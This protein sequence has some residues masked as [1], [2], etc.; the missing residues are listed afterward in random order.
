[1][2]K[3]LYGMICYWTFDIVKKMH[4]ENCIRPLEL[5]VRVLM[6]HRKEIIELEMIDNKHSF[7]GH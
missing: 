5:D 2:K 1:M 4:T 6:K 3:H 7:V